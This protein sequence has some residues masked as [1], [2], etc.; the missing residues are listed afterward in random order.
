MAMPPRVW[1]DE[2]DGQM[3]QVAL[4]LAGGIVEV[5]VTS[6]TGLVGRAGKYMG[7][8]EL[9]AL[10][11]PIGFVEL[12]APGNPQSSLVATTA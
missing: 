3:R 2:A 1:T 12:F 11:E 4:P 7:E 5:L 6:D 10:G 8:V 9:S